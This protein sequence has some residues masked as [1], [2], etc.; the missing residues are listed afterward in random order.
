MAFDS[1]RILTVHEL[2]IGDE[3]HSGFTGGFCVKWT[4]FY[5]GE[6]RAFLQHNNGSVCNV[7]GLQLRK[8]STYFA[9][10]CPLCELQHKV[11]VDSV[12]VKFLKQ[13]LPQSV[14]RSAF[15]FR[16]AQITRRRYLHK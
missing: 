5:K 4:V 12:E 15:K 14:M 2:K 1:Q 13:D 6:F 16:A 10:N 7:D 11:K 8:N 3:V 9:D